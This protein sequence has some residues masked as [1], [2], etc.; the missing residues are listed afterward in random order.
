[1]SGELLHRVQSIIK[2]YRDLHERFGVPKEGALLPVLKAIFG[3]NGIIADADKFWIQKELGVSP[4]HIDGLIT[5]YDQLSHDLPEGAR[6]NKSEELNKTLLGGS[7]KHLP[8]YPT[9]H[10]ILL[11]QDGKP[12]TS[13]DQYVKECKGYKAARI[14]IRLP[15]TDIISEISKSGLRGRGGGYFP[16]GKKLAVAAQEVS[17]HKFVIANADEGEPPTRKDK[18]LMDNNPHQLIEGMIISGRTIGAEFGFI[19]IRGDYTETAKRLKKAV[20]EAEEAGFLGDHIFGSHINFHI[21]VFEG[22]GSYVCGADTAL[23]QSLSGNRGE[24]QT[25]PPH[26]TEVGGG[27]GGYPTA[28]NNVETISNLPQIIRNGGEWFA[29]IGSP[30]TPGTKVYGLSGAVNRSGIYELPTGTTIRSLIEDYGLGAIGQVKAILPGGVSCAFLTEADLDTPLDVG[31]MRQKGTGLGSG[32]VVVLPQE[33]DVLALTTTIVEF[34]SEEACGAC[35]P[36]PLG[37][38]RALRV[39]ERLRMGDGEPGDVESLIELAGILSGTAKCGLGHTALTAVTSAI[40][41]FP[42]EFYRREKKY[43]E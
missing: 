12:I 22:A 36:C 28:M 34:F 24:S 29:R 41:I 5:F 37:I 8:Y 9:G 6:G 42:G 40:K 20:S 2:D 38:G 18:T 19:Y 16:V 27:L 17:K 39:L 32:T 21:R 25:T 43:G 23:L 13:L 1:M 4:A 26:T 3:V 15:V 30:D 11:P 31:S 33:T 10:E 35:L 7:F 14:A